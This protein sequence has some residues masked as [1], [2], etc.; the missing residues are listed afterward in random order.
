MPTKHSIEASKKA[1]KSVKIISTRNA[2]ELVYGPQGQRIIPA[3]T[4]NICDSTGIA[5]GIGVMQPGQIANPH[6]HEK[7]ESIIFILEGWAATLSGPDLKPAIHGPSDFA[8]I[9]EGIM[10]AAVNLSNKHRVV[11]IEIRN[12]KHFNGDIVLFPEMVPQAE[13]IAKELRA[14][15]E[16]GTLDMPEGWHDIVGKPFHFVEQLLFTNKEQPASEVPAASPQA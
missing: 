12:E 14:K 16:A 5:G 13:A 2:G 3:V 9:P 7:C 4:N 8:F 1:L 10:H 11:F 15:Y 6:L